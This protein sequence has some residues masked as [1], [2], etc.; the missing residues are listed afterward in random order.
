M[1]CFPNHPSG[2]L[3]PGYAGGRYLHE[4]LDGI[5]VH[6]HWTYTTPNRGLVKRSIGHLSYL[7]G[8]LLVSNRH[9][10]PPDVVIGSSPTFPAAEA[11]AWTAA[12]RRIP[13][14]M[15]VRDLWPAVF[16]ELGVT[17][18]RTLVGGLEM[19]ELRLYHRATRIV[20][21]TE[22]F[23][24]NLVRRGVPADK[25]LTI[26]NG[27]DLDY[28]TPRD[29]SSELRRRLG[30]GDAFLILY[31]GT[32]GISQ[33]LGAVLDAAER[34]RDR[35]DIR[36]L[37]VG[38]GAEKEALLE[39]AKRSGLG[40]AV[41]LDPVAK[42]EVRDFY[43]LADACLIP[44]RDIPLFDG[45]IPSKMFE[46][47]AM[48]RPLIGSVRGESAAILERSG[49]AVVTPPED[50]AAIADAVVALCSDPARRRA[51]GSAARDFVAEHHG[52]GLLAA[53]YLGLLEDAIEARKA[54]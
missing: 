8:A 38:E 3:Y 16:T 4:V 35:D 29:P 7:P 14:V 18:N 46:V 37:F 39:R 40:N 22:S 42:E 9:L 45:F 47:M 53:R 41:F 24:Q 52:R 6:R 54:A 34:L 27:A 23:R 30:L 13:F 20:T 49:G 31:I 28:W 32:H 21:V 10:E 33:G 11:A 26:P 36:F 48:G 44:L 12:S 19:L 25:V 50:G 17:R 15:E 5:S 1:T 2:R 51:M 43:A